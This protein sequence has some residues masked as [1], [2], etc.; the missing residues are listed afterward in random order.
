MTNLF[1]F[2]FQFEE[3]ILHFFPLHIKRGLV[4]VQK[5]KKNFGKRSINTIT[6]AYICPVSLLLEQTC[7]YYYLFTGVDRTHFFDIHIPHLTLLVGLRDFW[8]IL[9]SGTQK[10]FEMW[11]LDFFSKFLAAKAALDFTMLVSSFVSQ[12]VRSFVSYTFLTYITH[13]LLSWWDL[14]IF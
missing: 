7:K 2:I 9:E 10:K 12:F 11:H 8:K 14:E 4:G 6:R 13:I 3:W 1:I 5:I